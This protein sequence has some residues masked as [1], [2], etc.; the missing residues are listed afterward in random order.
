MVTAETIGIDNPWAMRARAV[1]LADRPLLKIKVGADDVLNRVAAVREGAPV[2]RLIVDANEAWSMDQ[3]RDLLPALAGLGVDLVEQPLPADEDAALAALDG[4]P[5]VPLCA[6]ESAHVADDVARLAGLY[7]AV[8]IKL[9]KTGG[10]TEALVMA[11]AAQAAGLTLMVGCMVGTSLA[12][13]PACVLAPRAAFVD[14]DGP[15]LLGRDRDPCLT[16]AAGHIGPPPAAL[17]G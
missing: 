14:L 7:Q 11:D 17:W 3:L 10:L 2:S 13:A 4:P 12:M 1:A 8:N 6:D 5:A 16:Y 15:V 9:D